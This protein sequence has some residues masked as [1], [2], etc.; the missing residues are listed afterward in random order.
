MEAANE[1]HGTSNEGLVP[2]ALT[3]RNNTVSGEGISSKYVP[4]K[5]YSWNAQLGEQACIDGVLIEN[6]TIDVPS[7]YGSININSVTGLYMLNNTI[8]ADK[9]LRSYSTS[10]YKQLQHKMIDGLNF[11]YK[12]NVS[13]VI[14]IVACDVDEN[15][16]KN[17]NIIGEN[18]AIPYSIK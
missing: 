18:I 12:Q 1:I 7:M 16:I 10:C 3:F 15:N 17:I 14:N 11:D 9:P 2:S 6:N 4:L 13:A 8:K 5:I